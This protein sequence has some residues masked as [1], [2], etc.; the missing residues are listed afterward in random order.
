MKSKI[1]LILFFILACIFLPKANAF[2]ATYYLDANNGNDSNL[3]T[4]S[5]PWKTL[6]RAYTW[7]SGAGLKVQE[8]DTVLMRNGDYGQFF[9]S[10][11]Q[12]DGYPYLIYRNNW[13]TYKADDGHNPILSEGDDGTSI[14][15]ENL[16]KWGVGGNG[17]SYLIF[18]GLTIDRVAKIEHTSYIKFINC[19]IHGAIAPVQGTYAPYCEDSAAIE[20]TDAN[21]ILVQGCTIHDSW[22]GIAAHGDYW[23]ITGNTIY[24]IGE[25]DIEATYGEHKVITNN[26]LRDTVIRRAWIDFRGI[27]NGTFNYLDTITQTSTG[28]VGVVYRWTGT[29][30][31]IWQTSSVDFSNSTITDNITGATLTGVWG[32]DTAHADGVQVDVGTGGYMTDI[33]IQNNIVHGGINNAAFK[34][35]CP[36]PNCISNITIANN[37]TYDLS[38]GI[39]ICGVNGI[40][41]INNTIIGNVRLLKAGS[42]L[43]GSI[44]DTMYN[45]IFESFSQDA[46][47]TGPNRV[48]LHGNN[49]FGNNPNSSGGSYSF[50]ADGTELVNTVPVFISASNNDYRL[51]ASSVAINFGNS[52]YGPLTDILGNSR[53][54]APDAGAYEYISSTPPAVIYGDI[55]GNGQLDSSDALMAAQYSLGLISL[56]SNQI[57]LGNVSGNGSVTAYDAALILL[58]IAGI[59]SKFPVE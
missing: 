25:D 26:I 17:R 47:G 28:A 58:K 41:I 34:M 4:S 55:S 59:I 20:A 19:H 15:I 24:G 46:D 16:D 38:P 52:N 11:R 31:D 8:G 56:T 12:S 10:T 32:M 14:S 1:F 33:L 13:V 3:G 35:V 5:Q 42:S 30:L 49:I 27:E 6:D 9:E 50:I 44:I 51:S 37:I 18:D 22:R 57:A 36:D 54:G 48:I 39:Q 7:Y 40:D 29:Y 43:G 45:N 21:N 53:V 2:A 23:T